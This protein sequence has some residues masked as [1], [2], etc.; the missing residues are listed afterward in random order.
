MCA[1]SAEQPDQ[2][3]LHEVISVQIQTDSGIVRLNLNPTHV[4]DI[5]TFLCFM[6]HRTHL[7]HIASLLQ[8][9]IIKSQKLRHCLSA[10]KDTYLYTCLTRKLRA[11]RLYLTALASVITEACCECCSKFIP[12]PLFSL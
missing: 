12:D 9:R 2:D 8:M 11:V 6:A 10:R 5:C 7:L 4:P 1:K 3:P